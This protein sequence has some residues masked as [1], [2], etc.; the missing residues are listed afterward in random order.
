MAKSEPIRTEQEYQAGLTRIREIFHAEEGTPE[1]DELEMLVDLV[2]IYAAEHYPINP[3]SPLA[4][5]EYYWGQ[6]SATLSKMITFVGGGTQAAENSLSKWDWRTSLSL[7]MP[8][9]Q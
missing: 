8:A 7:P 4:A 6:E 2:E 3:P 1:G 9:T 5:L